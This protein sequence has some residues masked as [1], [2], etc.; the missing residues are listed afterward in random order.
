MMTMAEKLADSRR[1]AEE[2]HRR[3]RLDDESF[4]QVMALLVPDEDEMVI[5]Q[6]VSWLISQDK[7]P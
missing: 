1:Q 7:E 5:K 2:L 6:I 4:T 3:G